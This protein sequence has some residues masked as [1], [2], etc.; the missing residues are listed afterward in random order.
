M[1]VVI[2]ADR[3]ELPGTKIERVG[4]RLRTLETPLIGF[5]L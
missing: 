3:Y 5:F 4:L 1:E 2:S